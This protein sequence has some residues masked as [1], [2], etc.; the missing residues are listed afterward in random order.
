MARYIT[1]ARKKLTRQA[2]RSRNWLGCRLAC[3][4]ASG[5]LGVVRCFRAGKI[6]ATR[7]D[8]TRIMP[9][10]SLRLLID[11]LRRQA[12]ILDGDGLTDRHLLQHFVQHG[13]EAA[14]EVLV[15]RHGPMVL[16]VAGRMLRQSE[17]AEDVFQATFLALVR[18]A[19]SIRRTEAVGS[20]LYKVAVRIAHSGTN[21]GP[22]ASRAQAPRGCD[23]PGVGRGAT[24]GR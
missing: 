23:R 11:R 14:F 21:P 17:D 8:D 10:T 1:P 2:G 3:Q 9:R 16:G 24:S 19:S 18:K 15:W 22:E 5:L 12:G 20:W 13:D 7:K 6:V 4:Q